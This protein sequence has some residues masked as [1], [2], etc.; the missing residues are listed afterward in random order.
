MKRT[1][2][3]IVGLSVSFTLASCG[4][5]LLE[6]DYQRGQYSSAAKVI[7]KNETEIRN[8]ANLSAENGALVFI[9]TNNS[10]VKLML[11]GDS[12]V[13]AWINYVSTTSPPQISALPLPSSQ[14][15]V[16]VFVYADTKLGK[17]AIIGAT[18]LDEDVKDYYEYA[19]VLTQLSGDMQD[20]RDI[21][22]LLSR[23]DTIQNESVATIRLKFEELSKSFN[24][25]S[26]QLKNVSDNQKSFSDGMNQQLARI[27]QQVKEIGDL[28][29]KL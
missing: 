1:S 27:Q 29:S 9:D 15:N 5:A 4:P 2:L 24:A 26:E 13:D 17:N 20:L 19:Q 12:P 23:S 28:V 22:V 11:P 8:F 7:R 6:S 14:S 18:E 3:T 16:A 25:L 10:S 21:T